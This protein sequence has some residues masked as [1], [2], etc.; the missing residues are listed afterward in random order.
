MTNKLMKIRLAC[1]LLVALGFIGAA[2]AEDPPTGGFVEVSGGR[3]WYQRMGA[4]EATPLLV[5]HGGPGSRSCG[6]LASLA[7]LAESRPVIVYDQL[8]SGRSDRPSDKTLWNLPRFVDEVVRLRAALQ[9][10]ELHLLGHS[11]GGAVALEYML[12]QHPT[13]VQSLTLA[14]PLIDTGQWIEDANVLRSRLPKETQAALSASELSQDYGS[15]AYR[16]A[17]DVYNARFLARSGWPMAPVPQCEGS[18]GFNAEIYLY[19]WGPTE[20]TATGTLLNFDRTDRLHEL[21][22]PVLFIVGR[23]DEARPETMLEFQQLVPGSIVEVIED[24]AHASMVDQ[25]ERFNGAVGKFLNSVEKQLR[26]EDI[27]GLQE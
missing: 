15:A 2:H 25:P 10:D 7:Q 22:L 19:M 24:A 1:L 14:G 18:G 13:G 4:G 17:A 3:I 26:Q 9:L 20:F 23:F 6:Y 21:T 5:I 11:W 16:T 12:T 8:G 27:T